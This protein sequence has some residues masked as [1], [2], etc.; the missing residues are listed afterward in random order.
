[1]NNTSSNSPHTLLELHEI[2]RIYQ[3]FNKGDKSLTDVELLKLKNHMYKT[4]NVLL[5]LGDR[6]RLAAL[7]SLRIYDSV[8][9][10]CNNRELPMD[11]I[12]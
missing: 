12:V 9:D 4:Y 5:P 6:F 7:E 11:Y 8:C 2:R 3:R 1:M 10:V